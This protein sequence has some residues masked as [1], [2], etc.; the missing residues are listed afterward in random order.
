MHTINCIIC[1][2]KDKRTLT[3]Q[4]FTDDYLNLVNPD[5]HKLTRRFVVCEG[6]GFVY[7]DPQLDERDLDVLYD[8]FRDSGF[9]NETPDQYF[10]R[11]TSLPRAESENCAKI[12]WMRARFPER[13]AAGGALLDI[14]CG[15]GVFIHTFLQNCPKWKACGVEPTAAFADLAR[16]RL[17][18]PVETD[19]Y[20]PGLFPSRRFDLITVNQV[21]EHVK[22]PVAFLKGVLATDLAKDGMVYIDVPHVSDFGFLPEDHDRFRMQHLWYFSEAS[23]GNVCR[24][25]GYD[26][27]FAD[28]QRTLR[29]RNNLIVAIAPAAS[30]GR[31]VELSRER[32]ESVLSLMPA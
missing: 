20:K 3:E 15:G 28:R 7:H 18:A 5:Y 25:A 2:S 23:L 31:K 16:R 30:A 19:N 9:R 10:D 8:K 4:T 17:G 32:P 21:L 24:L 12:E 22:D 1:K 29:G 13:L 11:I 26:V 6:C 14:G 27:A